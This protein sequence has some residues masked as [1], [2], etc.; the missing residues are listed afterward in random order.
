MKPQNEQVQQQT[1]ENRQS[2][3]PLTQILDKRSEGTT[4]NFIVFVPDIELWKDPKPPLNKS[5]DVQKL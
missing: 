5:K 3:E 4:F 1:K 2:I